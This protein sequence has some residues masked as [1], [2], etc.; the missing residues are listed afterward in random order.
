MSLRKR[1]W[2]I[3]EVARP[4]DKTSRAFEIF[5]LALIMLNVVAVI[6]G[7]VQSVHDRWSVLLNYFEIFPVIIFTLE[8]AAR[9]WSCTVEPRFSGM[10]RGRI[11]LALSGM[12]IIDLL[13]ILPFYLPMFGVDLR[14][15]R[16]LR[17]F[18]VLQNC[19]NRPVLC[20]TN[21][22]QTGIAR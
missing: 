14:L 1:T 22:N 6:F 19:K 4:G 3:V 5:I 13:A 10:I 16:V 17:L 18:R 9:L 20:L 21:S 11:R 7:T 8:Y 15:L 2:E 12:S